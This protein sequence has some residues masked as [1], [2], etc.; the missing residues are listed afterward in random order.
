MY[1]VGFLIHPKGMFVPLPKRLV[2]AKISAPGVDD[3]FA[4]LPEPTTWEI[5]RFAR[6]LQ[7]DGATKDAITDKDME[8]FHF[9]CPCHDLNDVTKFRVLRGLSLV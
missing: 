3:S 4:D 7:T 9:R 2:K 1:E 5:N 8:L 6:K